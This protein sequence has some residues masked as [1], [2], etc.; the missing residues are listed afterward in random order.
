LISYFSAQ[1]KARSRNS[2][3]D[4][5]RIAAEDQERHRNPDRVDVAIREVG[6]VAFGDVG[7]AVHREPLALGDVVEVAAELGFVL[8]VRARE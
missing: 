4:V 3:A 5:R 2:A 8:S 7:A 1:S 6:K